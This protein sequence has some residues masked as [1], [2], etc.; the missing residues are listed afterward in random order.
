MHLI[1]SK[2]ARFNCCTIRIIQTK[3]FSVVCVLEQTASLCKK[4]LQFYV[5]IN[6]LLY[7]DRYLNTDWQFGM[8]NRGKVN[9]HDTC[10]VYI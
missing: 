6:N 9:G 5:N 3:P 1:E 8:F 7:S 2:H 10:L 4:L